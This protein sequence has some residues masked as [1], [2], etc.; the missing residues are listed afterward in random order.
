MRS[1]RP[2]KIFIFRFDQY[3]TVNV[4]QLYRSRAN[5]ANVCRTRV[6]ISEYVTQRFGIRTIVNAHAIMV[7]EKRVGETNHV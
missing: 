3:D 2:P 7:L 4:S 5:S 1:V 6:T